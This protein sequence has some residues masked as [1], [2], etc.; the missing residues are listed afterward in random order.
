M[1]V[2]YEDKHGFV[3]MKYV[4]GQ[5]EGVVNDVVQEG[6]FRGSYQVKLLDTKTGNITYWYFKEHVMLE[7]FEKYGHFINP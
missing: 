7:N 6:S 2:R 4:W 5:Y 3:G 1:A